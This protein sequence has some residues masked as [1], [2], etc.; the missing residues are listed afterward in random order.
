MLSREIPAKTSSVFN[1]LSLHTFSLYHI[2]ITIKSHNKYRVQKI[3]YNYNQIWYGVLVVVVDQEKKKSM[4]LELSRGR[5]S[6][7]STRG[8]NRMLVV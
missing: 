7:F 2:T 6:K 3:E 5:G 8:S 4:D 1:S